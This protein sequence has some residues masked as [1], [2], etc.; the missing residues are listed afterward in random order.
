MTNFL[1]NSKRAFIIISLLSLNVLAAAQPCDDKD[2]LIKLEDLDYVGIKFNNLVRCINSGEEDVAR[3]QCG[4]GRLINPANE[5]YMD[6]DMH[7]RYFKG[8]KIDF[9]PLG[10]YYC[11][12]KNTNPSKAELCVESVIKTRSDWP[13]DVKNGYDFKFERK[14]K[15]SSDGNCTCRLKNTNNSYKICNREPPKPP[16]ECAP[17]GLTLAQDSEYRNLPN[18]RELECARQVCKCSD[19]TRFFPVD[20]AKEQCAKE[21][22]KVAA[23]AVAATKPDN[24]LKTCVD[25]WKAEALKCKKDAEDAN[26]NCASSEM[27]KEE[28]DSAAAIDAG[29]KLYVNSKAGSGAQQQCFTASLVASGGKSLLEPTKEVCDASLTA[30]NSSCSE[31]K[32]NELRDT[33]QSKV[34]T[35]EQPANESGEPTPNQKYFLDNVVAIHEITQEARKICTED[36]KKGEMGLSDLLK[37]V[38][39]ALDSS[40]KCMCQLSSGGP[41]CNNIPSSASCATN[42]SQPGCSVYGSIAVCTPGAGYDARL[43]NCQMNPKD[44]GCP[45]GGLSGGLVGFAGSGL[46]GNAISGGG[47]D[48]NIMAG[49]LKPTGNYDLAIGGDPG[50]TTTSLQLGPGS[51]SDSSP[52]GGGSFGGGPSGG[53][54]P[55]AAGAPGAPPEEKG[56][57]GLFNQARSFVSKAFGNKKSPSNSSLKNGK[58]ANG[59]DPNKFRPT[60]GIASKR[61]IGSKNQDIWKMS[62]DCM[63]AVTCQSNMNNFM[64]SPLRL[65]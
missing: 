18:A 33:C 19:N 36:A 52:G 26:K 10:Y 24:N 8:S 30:C 44:A 42:P 49:N 55:S 62:N 38:G 39:N 64:D 60:R 12:N 15:I 23:A 20:I 22:A 56:I 2:N 27:T 37:S 53:G 41:N 51:G 5:Q 48:P 4:E 16:D 63:Y 32:L 61:G 50:G 46:K 29:N 40:V 43:C 45:G 9:N 47:G 1:V 65:K 34:I 17:A 7:E 28:K 6:S 35:A 31:E 11:V 54:G 58:N 25:T 13:E 14:N 59:F 57:G 21:T 3:A